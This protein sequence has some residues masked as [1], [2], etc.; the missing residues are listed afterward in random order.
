VKRGAIHR[1]TSGIFEIIK[2]EK[3]G[4][5]LLRLFQ[6]LWILILKDIISGDE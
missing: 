2:N 5:L 4:I 1:S 6:N 3:G